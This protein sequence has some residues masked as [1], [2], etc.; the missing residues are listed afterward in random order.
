MR[1]YNKKGAGQIPAPLL[2]RKLRRSVSVQLRLQGCGLSAGGRDFLSGCSLLADSDPVRLHIFHCLDFTET[3]ALRIAVAEIAFKVL[4]IND[5]K[6]HCAKG[7]DRHTGAATN[8]LVV[9]HHHPA[10]CLIPGNGLDGADDQA[11]R[12]LALL[13]GHRDVETLRLPLHDLDPAPGCVRD[14]IMED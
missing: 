8:A 12:I 3:N 5:V 1:E 2:F 9:V 14:A 7:T 11:G 10:Q 6:A 13:T 4:S